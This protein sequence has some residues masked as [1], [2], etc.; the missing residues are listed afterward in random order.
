MQNRV[1]DIGYRTTGYVIAKLLERLQPLLLTERV[2]TPFRIPKRKTK[3]ALWR[4]YERLSRFTGPL[5][6]YVSPSGQQL[7]AT[8]VTAELEY[9]GSRVNV[10][11]VIMD[12]HEDPVLDDATDNIKDLAAETIEVNRIAVMK[13]GS[14]VF[15]AGG[16]AVD[17]R[18]EVASEITLPDLKRVVRS[19]KGNRVKKIT[20]IVSATAKVATE[21][22]APAYIALHHTDVSGDIANLAGF[23][24]IE[25]YSNDGVILPGE[26]GKVEQVRFCESD[27]FEPWEAAGAANASYTYLSS[28]AYSNSACDVYPILILGKQAV[29][30]VALQGKNA[31]EIFVHNPVSETG[32]ELARKGYVAVKF[33]QATAILNQLCIARLEVAC[34][35]AQ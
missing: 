23:T 18:V 25:K 5:P 10:S 21:P 3:T 19:M 6:E 20:D 17:T 26:I 14:N 29:G 32:D 16:A 27:L 15:Y 7:T 1:S 22:I 12:T 34:K 24:P 30:T 31:I 4:R 11:D 28:R 9:Y 13:A 2:C 8:D 35:Y 33:L